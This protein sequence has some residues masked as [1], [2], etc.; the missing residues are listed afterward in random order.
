M[1]L[2]VEGVVE[3]SYFYCFQLCVNHLTY[4]SRIEDIKEK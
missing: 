4:I 3:L 2:K 1:A